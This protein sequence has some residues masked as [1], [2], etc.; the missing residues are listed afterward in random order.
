MKGVAAVMRCESEGRLSVAL[1]LLFA[2]REKTRR[3]LLLREDS[4]E[5][6]GVGKQET[7]FRG[8]PRLR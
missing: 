7:Q 8:R 4:W 1:S 2:R 3:H 6:R 5:V